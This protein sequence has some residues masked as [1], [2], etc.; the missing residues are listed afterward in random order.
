MARVSSITRLSALHRYC[1]RIQQRDS[2][3]SGTADDTIVVIIERGT[4]A[5][6]TISTPLTRE[7]LTALIEAKALIS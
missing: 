2:T 6:T 3:F 1:Q 4:G 7:A 5:T